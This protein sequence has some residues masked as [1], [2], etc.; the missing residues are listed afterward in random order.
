MRLCREW[1][2][3]ADDCTIRSGRVIDGTIY[4]DEEYEKRISNA[5]RAQPRMTSQPLGECLRDVGFTIPEFKLAPH[6]RAVLDPSRVEP[7]QPRAMSQG[8]KAKSGLSASKMSCSSPFV[9]SS[10]VTR[11]FASSISCR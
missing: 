10:L 3:Y 2:I 6:E 7:S 11:Q 4:T 1:I 5:A 9:F 8:E